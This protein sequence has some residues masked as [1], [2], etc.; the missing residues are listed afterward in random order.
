MYLVELK[1]SLRRRCWESLINRSNKY[2]EY[3]KTCRAY[4]SFNTIKIM[5]TLCCA[6]LILNDMQCWQHICYDMAQTES[7]D[8]QV[9]RV[10]MLQL[11]C[12]VTALFEQHFSLVHIAKSNYS[13]S[14]ARML[15]SEQ[16][17]NQ[18][19]DN[20]DSTGKMSSFQR[21]I[22][23]ARAYQPMSELSCLVDSQQSLDD[24]S[25]SSYPVNTEEACSASSDNEEHHVASSSH[26]SVENI[27]NSDILGEP[28]FSKLPDSHHNTK[29]IPL[30]FDILDTDTTSI[31][32]QKHNASNVTFFMPQVSIPSTKASE[33][34][35]NDQDVGYIKILVCGDSGMQ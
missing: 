7:D 13:L 16:K 18:A 35:S 8:Q 6:C 5:S 31:N 17:N 23:V 11:F 10:T 27:L 29:H 30:L 3:H 19:F 14:Y 22:P 32:T 21:H 12:P 20:S 28:T 2:N 26:K 24:W 9:P 4:I 1:S 25:T 15:S 33:T 34:L